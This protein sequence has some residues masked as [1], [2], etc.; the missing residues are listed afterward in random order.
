MKL[1]FQRAT[2][3]ELIREYGTNR[4]LGNVLQNVESKIKYYLEKP[5]YETDKSRC[6]NG[7]ESR[8]QNNE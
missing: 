3:N 4:S 6:Y 8:V 1:R 5:S 7:G 2:I